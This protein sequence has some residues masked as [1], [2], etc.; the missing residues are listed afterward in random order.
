MSVPVPFDADFQVIILRSQKYLATAQTVSFQG[1]VLFFFF[2]L[3]F[4][5]FLWTPPLWA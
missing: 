1:T 3:L 2:Q 4:L 5:N